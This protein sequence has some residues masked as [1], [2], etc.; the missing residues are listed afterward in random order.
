MDL[1]NTVGHFE[2]VN[3]QLKQVGFGGGERIHVRVSRVR[4]ACGQTFRPGSL[5]IHARTSRE[6]TVMI[7]SCCHFASPTATAPLSV[8]PRRVRCSRLDRCP[9][10][11]ATHLTPPPQSPPPLTPDLPSPPLLPPPSQLRAAFA[12]ATVLGRA[13]IL[14]ELWCG[15]DRYWAPHP[16]TLP[17]SRFKLPFLCP[18][19]HILDLENGLARKLDK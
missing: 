13:V 7:P 10:C 1:A 15:L 3:Y 6:R 11:L 5:R 16:G 12:L 4:S 8:S 18:A 19:D 17:G 14:P 2:L 9:P